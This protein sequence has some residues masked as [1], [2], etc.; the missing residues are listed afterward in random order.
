MVVNPAP[1]L[2]NVGRRAQRNQIR[3]AAQLLLMTMRCVS[4][5]R[6]LLRKLLL[7]LQ[8]PQLRQP[9]ALLI[10]QLLQQLWLLQGAVEVYQ[11]HVAKSRTLM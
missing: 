4:Q 10:P 9:H 11:D 3:Q 1:L 5:A 2:N 6:L 8:Q 7:P